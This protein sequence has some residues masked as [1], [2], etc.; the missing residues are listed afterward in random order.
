MSPGLIGGIFGSLVGV[1]GGIIGTFAAV[2]NTSG[3]REKA[4][5]IKVSVIGWIVGIV[6]PA[7]LLL[8]PSPWRFLLWVPYGILL[9]VGILYWNRTQARI[10]REEEQNPRLDIGNRRRL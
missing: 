3:P 4:F 1:I 9:P 10:R 2:R 8:L 5:T 7:L 6:F